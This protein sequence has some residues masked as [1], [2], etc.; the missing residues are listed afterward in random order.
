MMKSAAANGFHF[1]GIRLHDGDGERVAER[2]RPGFRLRR[3]LKLLKL[4]QTGRVCKAV[5]LAEVCGVSR[6][7]VFRDIAVLQEAGIGV[8]YDE[9]RR[10]Y[11]IPP[12]RAKRSADLTSTQVAA[13]LIACH[14]SAPPALAD[15]VRR[16]A[17]K[18]CARLPRSVRDAA[19]SIADNVVILHQGVDD[20]AALRR[21]FAA[22]LQALRERRRLRMEYDDGPARE[23]ISVNVETYRLLFT[24]ETWHVVGR[25]CED[26]EVHAFSLKRMRNAVPLDET[27]VIPQRFNLQRFLGNAWRVQRE[28]NAYRVKVLFDSHVAADIAM[29]CWHRTQQVR[30]L[31]DGRLEWRVAVDG[32]DE[33]TAWILGFGPH[34]E[35]VEPVELRT[36]I[37]DEIEAMRRKYAESKPGCERSKLTKRNS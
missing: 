33:I 18:I 31:D 4:L 21:T 20:A 6:R 16:A 29:T 34:A 25:S 11:F 15:E 36:R 10:G 17:A 23:S 7:T 30:R 22:C 19:K 24:H 1:D 14:G 35:V 5:E 2:R 28:L 32:L 9:T 27:Y 8:M 12:R 26:C 37:R 3:T 13:L